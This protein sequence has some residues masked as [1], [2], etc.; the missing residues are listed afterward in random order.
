MGKTIIHGTKENGLL[1]VEFKCTA[2]LVTELINN[3]H[4]MSEWEIYKALTEIREAAERDAR[5]AHAYAAALKAKK[6]EGDNGRTINH[7]KHT[8]R[9]THRLN[10]T[11]LGK[12]F[13]KV[14]RRAS[15]I[16]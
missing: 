6:E 13:S 8:E 10:K 5:T 14:E 9:R 7:D 3:Q 4:K 12:R 11:P 2:V 1:D 16:R 15:P